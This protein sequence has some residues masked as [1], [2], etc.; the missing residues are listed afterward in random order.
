MGVYKRNRV[1]WYRFTW[2]G[3]AIRESTKQ[4]NKR[5]A[6]QIEAA[7]KT[8]L[9]KGEV[10][11]RD[12]K[13][14]PTLRNFAENDFLPF[15]A[16]TF[17]A[18]IKTKAFYEYGVKSLLAYDKLANEPIDSIT[19]EKLAGYVAKRQQAE[20]QIA[21]IN[22]ELQVLRRMLHLAQEWGKVEKILPRVRMLP[23][24][25]RR[26]RVLHWEE[27]KRY[28]NGATPL[29]HDVAII[30]IDCGLRPEECFRLKW[31]SVREGCIEIQYGKTDNAR[32]R[33]PMSQRVAAVLAMRVKTATS[34]FVFPAP[35]R[36]GH[37]E[38]GTLKRPHRHAC[39]GEEN[40]DK[41][42]RR[43]PDEPMKWSVEPFQLYTLRHTCLT[44]WAPHMDPWT[45]AYLAGHR[46]MSITKRYIHPQEQN[47]RAAIERA[48]SALSGHNSGHTADEVVARDSV[49]LAVT[50]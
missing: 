8:S 39:E 50:N 26:E 43:Q 7:H 15:V 3:A 44:R 5:I 40:R 10:G 16:A 37:I 34:D 38:P 32:R 45:L 2:K 19:S 23:G 13:P 4:T 47:T 9:A 11:I 20:L 28:L 48:R 30:L 6:E 41:N 21:S 1:W 22:R 12:R 24:E 42:A 33:I 31:E 35:T 29:L 18:K 27:E 36:S 14:A 25:R 46:D 17:A 49:N